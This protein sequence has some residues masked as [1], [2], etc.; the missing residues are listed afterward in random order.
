MMWNSLFLAFFST[1]KAANFR[2][3]LAEV[4]QGATDYIDGKADTISGVTIDGNN[5]YH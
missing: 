5:S 3:S 4:V 2:M 1:V